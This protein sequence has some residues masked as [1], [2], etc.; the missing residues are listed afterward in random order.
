[1]VMGGDLLFLLFWRGVWCRLPA[2]TRSSL[3]EAL[4]I[5]DRPTIH[6]VWRGIYRVNY[7]NTSTTTNAINVTMFFILD[8]Q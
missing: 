7:I 3:A 4:A 5:Q 1:M 2:L 6:W 8:L